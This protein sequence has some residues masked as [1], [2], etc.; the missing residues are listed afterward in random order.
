M[1]FETLKEV[2]QWKTDGR[3]PNHTYLV[4]GMKMYG[5]QK[6]H[7]GPIEMFKVPIMLNKARRQ[8]EKIPKQFSPFRDQ[9]DL[10]R[11]QT[12]KLCDLK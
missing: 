2:S 7:Y 10:L 4:S 3:Q 11:N 6:Y 9:M 8:F 5:Y 12:Q 1:F